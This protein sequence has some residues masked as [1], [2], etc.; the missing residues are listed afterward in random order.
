MPNPAIRRH[1]TYAQAGGASLSYDELMIATYNPLYYWILDEAAGQTTVINYGSVGSPANGLHNQTDIAGQIAGPN[2]DLAALFAAGS[3]DYCDVGNSGVDSAWTQTNSTLLFYFRLP[4]G[5]WTN[6]GNVFMQFS[7]GSNNRAFPRHVTNH[8]LQTR[9]F[10][11]NT[12]V[13]PQHA[14]SSSGDNDDQWHHAALVWNETGNES[15]LY[16]D[17][18]LRD[19][20][21]C[22]AYDDSN[23]IQ[24]A[25]TTI[26]LQGQAGTPNAANIAV[27]R[28]M[29]VPAIMTAPQI[30]DVAQLTA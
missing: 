9:F 16:I 10:H 20:E 26:G 14:L 24:S 1:R 13:V 4:D 28:V 30:L 29:L 27:S 21:I 5:D 11:D 8:T 17:G 18:V 7:R 25:E 3:G 2:G 22:P 19:T 23:N 12:S 15:Y 6:T